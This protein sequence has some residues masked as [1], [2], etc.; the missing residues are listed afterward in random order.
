[1][2]VLHVIPAVAVRYGGPSTAIVAMCRALAREGLEPFIASTD[3]DG[4]ERL[5]VPVGEASSWQEVPAIFFR[6]QWSEAFK[7]SRP[8]AR[9][10]DRHVADFN[11]VHI[12]GVLSHAPLAA[13]AACR[14]A[15]VPYIVRTIGTV[16]PWSLDQRPTRKRVLMTLAGYRMLR[17]AAAVQYTSITERSLVEGSWGLPK[18]VVVPLGIDPALLGEPMVEWPERLQD[19]YVLTLSRLHPV[20]NLERLVQ[21]FVDVVGTQPALRWRLVIAGSGDPP[22]VERLQRLAA[23]RGMAGRVVFPGWVDG[24]AKRRLV[25]RASLFALPSLH[26]SFSL[27]LLESLAAGVPALVSDGV[28]LAETVRQAHA[29]WVAGSD[30]ES[31]AG[32]LTAALV[33]DHRRERYGLAARE[34]ARR[35]AW[36]DVAGQLVDLYREV[37]CPRPRKAPDAV[38]IH[39]SV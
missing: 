7:Y 27:S 39:S 10:L 32:G 35:F 18:G 29:G 25:R 15:G 13:A 4:H 38:G 9:W 37:R 8:L 21:A 3:A 24:E 12:H 34:L 11:V 23:H 19:P 6:R 1:M 5:D 33:P 26:E 17:R 20:K 14:R 16:D 30:R 28:H 31:L 22:Y 36:P 2:K